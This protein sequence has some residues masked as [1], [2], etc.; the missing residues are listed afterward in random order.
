MEK[1]FMK[2]GGI[3]KTSMIDY[4]G[5]IS[6]TVFTS[7]CNF[8]CP[9]C[10]NAGLISGSQQTIISEEMVLNFL[11]ERLNLIEAVTI[12]GGEPTLSTGLENFMKRV[13]AMGFAVK[14]DTN[15]SNPGAIRR[16]LEKGLLDYIAL[17][18]KTLTERY[19][20]Y[21]KA[22]ENIAAALQDSIRVIM[23]SG[24]PY[25]FRTT[26][27][28]PLLSDEIVSRLGEMI[29]GASVWIFQRCNPENVLDPTFFKNQE[30]LFSDEE[31]NNFRKIA[32]NFVKIS[33]LR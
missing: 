3:Q 33:R 7:G 14:L 12:T 4:P 15:G 2:F 24:I 25:E 9:Y 29:E 13:K 22:P 27:V 10:H 8:A 11:Q 19:C 18:L 21:V 23:N 16:Y 28:K 26:C 1:G 30:R 20:Q 32:L 31:L 5:K 6:C 17:D